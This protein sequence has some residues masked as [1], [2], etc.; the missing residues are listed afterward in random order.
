MELCDN[1]YLREYMYV[2]AKV[3]IPCFVGYDKVSDI[4]RVNLLGQLDNPM[5]G[6]LD[7]FKRV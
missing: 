5:D 2:R 7:N 3:M 6:L 4:G 1:V